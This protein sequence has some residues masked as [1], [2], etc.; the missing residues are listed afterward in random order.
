[1]VWYSKNRYYTNN[2]IK[3]SD[4]NIYGSKFEAGYGN[5]LE[6]RKK[7]GDIKD[8]Q[9]QVNMPLK[10]NGY[11]LGVYIADFIITHNDGSKEVVETK[12]FAT[13]V[14]RLKWKIVEALYSDE[15]KLTVEFMGKG[16]LRHAK[17]E[18]QF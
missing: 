10:V 16:K 13:P 18:I 9:T 7:A 8:Y 2:S 12:G 6:L 14:F 1:M 3:G 11:S 17:K 4:G 15:Y 5:E